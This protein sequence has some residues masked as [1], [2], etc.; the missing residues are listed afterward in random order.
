M[1]AGDRL[2]PEEQD[3]HRFQQLDHLSNH[4]QRPGWAKG[5]YSYHWLLTF[6]HASDLQTLAARCQELFRN[7][8]HFDLVPLDANARELRLFGRLSCACSDLQFLCGV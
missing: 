7:L 8:P 2:S 3:W 1:R 5:R 6:G 4:W